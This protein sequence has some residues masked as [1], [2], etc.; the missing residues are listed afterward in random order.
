MER[1]AA[2]IA[3]WQ[4]RQRRE[5]E[6]RRA[7]EIAGQEKAARRQGGEGAELAGVAQVE[8][9]TVGKA[10]GRV[11]ARRGAGV[12]GVEFGEEGGGL[13][14]G[15]RAAGA[16]E[17]LGAPLGEGEAEKRQVEQPFAGIVDDIEI[18]RGRAGKAR[19]PL[20]DWYLRTRR[21]WE[22]RRVPSGQTG[23]RELSAAR[24]CS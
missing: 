3:R 23:S 15:G 2:G 4:G 6:G 11:L 20:A 22:T 21:S 24:C 10:P 8:R 12:H 13:G 19:P 17:G 16:L 5:G 9:E 18:E 14:A 1:A 7:F